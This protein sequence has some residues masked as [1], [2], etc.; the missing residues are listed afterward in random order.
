MIRTELWSKQL[1]TKCM[2]NTNVNMTTLRRNL[3]DNGAEIESIY[4]SNFSPREGNELKFSASSSIQTIRFRRPTGRWK[5][6][7]TVL[8]SLVRHWARVLNA[9]Y[10]V[11]SGE[12]WAFGRAQNGDIWNH[13]NTNFEVKKLIHGK[14]FARLKLDIWVTNDLN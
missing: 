13:Q 7:A 1:S 5:V 12:I 8:R 2:A 14:A 6:P 10:D 9:I 4:S 3:C 11:M